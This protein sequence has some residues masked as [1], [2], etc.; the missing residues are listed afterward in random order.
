MSGAD[1]KLIVFSDKGGCSL[2]NKSERKHRN[3]GGN[4]ERKERSSRPWRLEWLFHFTDAITC[5]S[6][7]GT[8]LMCDD[9]GRALSG[10]RPDSHASLA[11]GGGQPGGEVPFSHGSFLSGES[12]FFQ[13]SPEFPQAP[14]S[15]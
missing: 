8:E 15:R 12:A 4:E 13:S 14:P 2:P 1:G 10:P 9:A 6:L 5:L 7:L 11:V 3:L